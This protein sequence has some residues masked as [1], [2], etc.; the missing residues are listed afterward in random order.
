MIKCSTSTD[1]DFIDK[2]ISVPFL[3]N[4]IDLLVYVNRL[5][6]STLAPHFILFLSN[7]VSEND[8]I[9]EV[10]YL[11]KIFDLIADNLSDESNDNDIKASI[12]FFACFASLKRFP[13]LDCVLKLHNLFFYFHYKAYLAIL[14]GV[15]VKYNEELV[16]TCLWGIFFIYFHQDSELLS[17]D[18]FDISLIE[19]LIESCEFRNKGYHLVLGIL[20]NITS[21]NDGTICDRVLNDRIA[22][23]ILKCLNDNDIQNKLK[24]MWV[25]SNLSMGTQLRCLVQYNFYNAILTLMK[26]ENNHKVHF[27]FLELMINCF[28]VYE[29]ESIVEY[30]T[31]LTKDL[32]TIIYR[33]KESEYCNQLLLILIDLLCKTNLEAAFIC[34]KN[35]GIKDFLERCSHMENKEIQMQSNE[36]LETYFKEI[37]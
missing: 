21:R 22:M 14:N 34:L 7:I 17:E 36:L 28:S 25:V 13:D 8:Y 3:Q 31:L 20:G 30:E 24:A 27:E 15:N 19:E 23:F 9:Q 1:K 5:Q 35:I 12:V 26:E 4:Y 29:N 11:Y 16:N 37:A 32:F 18:N 33:I 10:F 2:F 6:F